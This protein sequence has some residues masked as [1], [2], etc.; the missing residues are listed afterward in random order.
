MNAP[1][2]HRHFASEF[3]LTC[4]LA[5]GPSHISAVSKAQLS[6]I[7]SDLHEA[8]ASNITVIDAEGRLVSFQLGSAASPSAEQQN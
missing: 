7:L 1:L 5:T 3:Y 4:N 6:E 8:G 2:Q